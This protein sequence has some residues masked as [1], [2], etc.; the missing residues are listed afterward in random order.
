M[1]IDFTKNV[2]YVFTVMFF[3]TYLP[4]KGEYNAMS[5][6]LS[7]ADK[8]VNEN[9]YP[10]AI[11]LYSQFIRDYSP[12][13]PKN[14]QLKYADIFFKGYDLCWKQNRFLEA[15]EFASFGLKATSYGGDVRGEIRF[16]GSIANLLGSFDDYERAIYYYKKGY[17]LALDYNYP[18]LQWKFLLSL[19]SPNVKLGNITQAKE[20]FRKM[21]LVQAPDSALSAFY[22]EYLQGIIASA[23]SS[24]ELAGHFHRR[25]LAV[26]REN[27]MQEYAVNEIWELGNIFYDKE[28]VDSA[29]HYYN[30]ALKEARGLGMSGH[31]PKIYFSLGKV[32]QLRGDTAAYINYSLLHKAAVDSIF[33]ISSYNSKRNS[34]LEYEELVKDNTIDGLNKRIWIQMSVLISVGSILLVVVF[35]YI[36]LQKRIKALRYANNKLIDRNR[37]LI[38]AEELNRKLMDRQLESTA[39]ESQENGITEEDVEEMNPTS[40]N[41]YLSKDQ[42][43]ILLSRIRKV[44]NESEHPFNPDFSLNTL[45]QLVKSNTKYVSYVINETYGKNFKA[46]LNELRVREA[47]KMLE[48]HDN[49]ANYTIQAISEEVGY[50]SSTSFIIAFKKLVGMTPSVYQKLSLERNQASDTPSDPD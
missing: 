11:A 20:Y 4:A 35:F 40:R 49:Y 5:N 9:D 21:K 34:L 10:M 16:I 25:A 26:A 15:L 46:M 17:K 36:L 6:V 24:T 43:D 41:T 32:S 31:I 42:T 13:A 33:N 27:N 28:E 29:S 1:R 39:A 47:S 22:N 38:K 48:D 3:M 23:D 14:E 7:R 50:K 19:V 37:E 45:A 44:L 12:E 8:A 18:D 30:V 2:V